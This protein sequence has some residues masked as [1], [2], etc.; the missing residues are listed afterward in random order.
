MRQP[1]F[2]VCIAANIVAQC[3][4]VSVGGDIGVYMKKLALSFFAL[5]FL[6]P[7]VPAANAQVVVQIGHRHHYHHYYHHHYYHHYHH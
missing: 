7:L 2:R 4:N 6:A 3:D 1:N 5:L